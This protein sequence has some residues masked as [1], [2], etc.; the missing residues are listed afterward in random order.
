MPEIITSNDKGRSGEAI[1]ILNQKKLW[2][3]PGRALENWNDPNGC[4]CASG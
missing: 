2:K 1:G 3:G 4:I